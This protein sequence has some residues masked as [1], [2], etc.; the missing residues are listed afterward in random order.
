[1]S[2]EFRWVGGLWGVGV[3]GTC[4]VVGSFIASM[5]LD[6]ICLTSSV[7]N[8]SIIIYSLLIRE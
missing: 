6:I 3:E 2:A 1:M 8:K 7:S 4:E 5:I